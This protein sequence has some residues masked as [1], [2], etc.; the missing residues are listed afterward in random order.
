[1]GAEKNFRE[2]FAK[3]L[4]YYMSINNKRQIDLVEDLRIPRATV[5]NWC[6]GKKMPEMVKIDMLAKYFNVNRSDLLEEKIETIA[7]HHDGEEWTE[8]ELQAIEDFK[9]FIRHRRK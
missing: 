6:N 7:A 9:A 3:R 5:S 8:D 1:M 4:N 2:V